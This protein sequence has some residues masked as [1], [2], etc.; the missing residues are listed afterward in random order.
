LDWGIL[1]DGGCNGCYGCGNIRH[2]CGFEMNIS[3]GSDV[4]VNV[5]FC[6]RPGFSILVKSSSRHGGILL[7]GGSG[8]KVLGRSGGLVDGGNLVAGGSGVP[9]S[10]E[11][12]LGSLYLRGI[13][14]LALEGC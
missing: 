10:S 9:G 1:L 6:L 8:N 12:S 5:R 7:N 13:S 4:F 2:I 11:L 3:F 14:T